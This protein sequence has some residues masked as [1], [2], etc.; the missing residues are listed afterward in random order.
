MRLLASHVDENP[1]TAQKVICG[2]TL[3]LTQQLIT[4]FAARPPQLWLVTRDAVSVASNDRCDGL[5]ESTIWGFGRTLARELPDLRC[6][7]VDLDSSSDFSALAEEITSNDGEPEIAFRDGKRY[8]SRLKSLDVQE[9]NPQRLT[10]SERGSM[11]RLVTRDL[12]RRAPSWDEIEV[13]PE[14][15]ALNFRDVLNVLGM[16]PGDPGEPGF[17]LCGRITRAGDGVKN[18]KPGDRVMGIAWHCLA[19]YVNTP[20]SL[21]MPVP[22]ELSASA[23]ATLPN[24]FLTAHY[25]LNEL[26]KIKRGDRVLVHAATGGVGLAAVQLARRVGAEIFAT[27]GS[28]QKREYL[29]SCGIT[30]VYSSRTLDFAREILEQT[31]GKG[32]DLVLN[33][34]AGDFVAAGFDVLADGGCFIEMGKNAIWSEE[35]VRR[36]GKSI[37]YFVVD[38]AE[39]ISSD[40]AK[41]RECFDKITSM[42]ADGAI[43]PLPARIF[44]FRHAQD[45]FSYMAQAKHIGKVL[46]RH[47]AGPRI[48]SD[49]TYLIT[50]GLGAIGIRTAAHLVDRGAKNIVLVGRGTPS[51]ETLEQI[52]RMQSAG[53]RVEVRAADVSRRPEM[54]EVFTELRSSMPPLRGVIH[55]AG[56]VDDGVLSQQNWGRFEAVFAAKIAGAWNLHELTADDSLDFFVLFSS[57]ASLLGSPSQSS[58]SAGNAFLDALAH[59]RQSRGLPALSLNWGAWAEAGMAARVQAQGRRRVLSGVRAMTAAECLGNFDL[60]MGTGSAQVAVADV[61]WS[62]FDAREPMLSE[63]TRR[64]SRPELAPEKDSIVDRLQSAPSQDRRKVLADY[65]REQVRRVVGL[66]GSYFIDERQPLLR[67]G[68]D[69]LMAVEFRNQLSAALKKPLPATLLVDYPTL[70][71]VVDFL[72]P[73]VESSSKEESRDEVFECIA[74]LSDSEAE[75]LL[76]EELRR[77]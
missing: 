73:D 69:S 24:A 53:A 48:E 64:I 41:I 42:I 30:H 63:L 52:A 21:V 50:G 54:E 75:E 70:E 39:V 58:Y 66:D 31:E 13:E 68:L 11:D 25:C 18:Y 77:N 3:A 47:P 57:V 61:D 15:C 72:S 51:G 36:L 60:A 2:T 43:V 28:D 23:A 56:I 8:I 14:F 7:R 67:M 20:A 6:V 16:Y 44:D 34:L 10:V 22:K 9:A 29:R 26:G 45:A 32:V 65:L 62:Q 38:L 76:K 19:S 46:L 12:E 17:E 27:A 33:S 55:S 59:Y 1:L 49:G 71:A 35:R 4:R 37:R 5:T 74:A 40:P